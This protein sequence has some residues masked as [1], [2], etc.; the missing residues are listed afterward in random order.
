MNPTLSSSNML[1]MSTQ[2]STSSSDTGS[3]LPAYHEIRTC[4]E[5]YFARL[6]DSALGM[7]P[8]TMA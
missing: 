8:W 3:E 7:G 5:S 6:G 1:L 2:T 4:T